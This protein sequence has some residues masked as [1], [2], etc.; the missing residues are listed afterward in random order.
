MLKQLFRITSNLILDVVLSMLLLVF[1]CCI[2][3]LF[4][5]HRFKFG[6]VDLILV[7]GY[8]EFDANRWLDDNGY[9]Y[10]E[11]NFEGG[12]AWLKSTSRRQL[13]WSFFTK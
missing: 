10:L 3:L 6:L 12:K 4:I 7:I 1:N 11:Y 9:D 13:E 5:N 8:Y 2:S